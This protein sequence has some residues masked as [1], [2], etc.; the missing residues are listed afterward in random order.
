MLRILTVLLPS[1]LVASI[2]MY[3]FSYY[4]PDPSP[5]AEVTRSIIGSSVEG[6]EIESYTFGTGKTH[7]AIVGGIHGGY[8]WNTSLLA[9]ELIAHFTENPYPKLTALRSFPLRI[10]TDFMQLQARRQT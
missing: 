5:S 7:I 8:E 10:Q 3:F 4:T 1:L 9:Y 6:R 2:G